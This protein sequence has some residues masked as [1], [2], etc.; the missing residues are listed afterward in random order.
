MF[1]VAMILL[2]LLLLLLLFAVMS[3]HDI[4]SFTAWMTK[5]EDACSYLAGPFLC[6]HTL[7]RLNQ[8]CVILSLLMKNDS[9]SPDFRFP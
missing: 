2:L 5:A 9:F 1:M 7:F 4:T 8:R 3:V 6:V